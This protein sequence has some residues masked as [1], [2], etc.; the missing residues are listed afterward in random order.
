MDPS[1]EKDENSPKGKSI[2][3][4]KFPD[5]KK[6]T[7]VSLHE[8]FSFGLPLKTKQNHKNISGFY[9]REES[10]KLSIDERGHQ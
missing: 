8:K 1:I 7:P 2:Q 5:Q 6:Y 9:R 10:L 3:P 4:Q